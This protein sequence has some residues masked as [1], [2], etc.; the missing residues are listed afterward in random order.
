[1]CLCPVNVSCVGALARGA[2]RQRCREVSPGLLSSEETSGPVLT[3]ADHRL[4][5][6]RP[7]PKAKPSDS[8]ST[9][10]GGL[11]P[12]FSDKGKLSGKKAFQLSAA[13]GK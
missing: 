6:D 5:T 9:L 7:R 12:D 10:A 13:A 4:V 1:M 3:S 8:P 2:S 11:H